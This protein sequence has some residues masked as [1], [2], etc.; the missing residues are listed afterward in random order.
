MEGISRTVNR[1]EL[2]VRHQLLLAETTSSPSAARVLNR[3]CHRRHTRSHS[4]PSRHRHPRRC[5]ENHRISHSMPRIHRL[6]LQ[7]PLRCTMVTSPRH[8]KR[9]MEAARESHSRTSDSFLAGAWADFPYRLYAVV[10]YDFAAERPDELD[11][12]AGEPIIVIAQSNHE[13]YVRP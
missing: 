13:W 10:Q 6:P 5:P 12:K 7:L 4:P 9:H 2:C 3:R 8:Q 11:A 1:G